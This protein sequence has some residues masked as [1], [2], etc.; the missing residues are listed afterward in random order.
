MSKAEARRTL[1]PDELQQI[2]RSIDRHFDEYV[3]EIRRYLM[4]PGFSYTG[5][6]MRESADLTLRLVKEVCPQAEEIHGD[7]QISEVTEHGETTISVPGFPIIY[8]RRESNRTNTKTLIVY[9]LYDVVQ[10]EDAQDWVFPPFEA[11]IAKAEEIFLPQ[12]L[13]DVI[14][15]R[16]AVNHK[17]PGAAFLLTL[18]SIL[19]VTGDV[20]V[21]LI[22]C[23]EGEEEIGSSSFTS[24]VKKNMEKFRDAN[25]AYVPSMG[26]GLPL[27]SV[28]PKLILDRGYKGMICGELVAESGDWGGT[29]DHRRL[30]AADIAWVD[31]PLPRLVAAVNSIIDRDGNVLIDDF[32]E[33]YQPP[34]AEEDKELERIKA[35]FNEERTKGLYNISR[36]KNNLPGKELVTKWV[37]DPALNI[38]GFVS[39]HTGPLVNTMLPM[40]AVAK[41][42]FRIV[43]NMTTREV[44][45]K[46]RKHLDKR[47][48]KDIVVRVFGRYEWSKSPADSDIFEAMRRA[49]KMHG[50]ECDSQPIGFAGAPLSV[51]NREP[52]NLPI[53]RSGVGHGARAHRAN[54]YITIEGIRQFMKHEAT[55]LYEY[56]KP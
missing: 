35:S 6:G 33:N 42:D 7:R 23:I 5:E 25:G 26:R 41:F 8:G 31:P 22:F 34:N 38:D 40:R 1:L 12:A 18:K 28:P 30:G 29:R 53:C 15:A 39:G 14:V 4:Q 20:P 27:G 24:F 54:E 51:F 17:G 32:L 46:L 48:F 11:R 19:E 36:F 21:N 56:A 43:P 55:F 52:L 47:G 50:I 49:A 9:Y 2:H 10:V 16:A 45:S 44:V 13:G 3:A 37:F